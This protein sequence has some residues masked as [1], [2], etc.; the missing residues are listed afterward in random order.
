MTLEIAVARDALSTAA[1]GQ[2]RRVG[3]VA[4]G[5]LGES[6]HIGGIVSGQSERGAAPLGSGSRAGT[7][8]WNVDVKL[9]ADAAP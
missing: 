1:A 3:S 4:S 8:D 2:E 6:L 9:E 7:S 5:R